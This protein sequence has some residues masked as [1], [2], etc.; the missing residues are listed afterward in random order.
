[1][2]V[3]DLIECWDQSGATK[4]GELSTNF[5]VVYVSD[6]GLYDIAKCEIVRFL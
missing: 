4:F 6:L 1:M 2:Q 5:S 3:K